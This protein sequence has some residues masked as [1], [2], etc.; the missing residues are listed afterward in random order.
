MR[1]LLCCIIFAATALTAV[2]GPQDAYFCTTEGAKLHYER[3]ETDSG[4]LRWRHVMSIDSVKGGDVSYNSLFTK[5]GG[6]RMYGGPVRLN[7]KISDSGDVKMD[8]AQSVASVFANMFG[9]RNVKSEGAETVLPAHMKPG[10]VLKDA[11]GTATAGLASMKVDVSER[12]VLRKETLTTPAGTFDCVVVREHKV[13][14]GTLR[15]RV[16]TADTW[17]ARGVGMV[18]H[19]TYDKHMKLETSEVLIKIDK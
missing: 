3:T 8:V 16:T 19:D 4:A 18:R 13:E 5:P 14:K 9:G 17:Y 15:N 7:V 6:G 12:K 10:D 2:A 1:R 11:S